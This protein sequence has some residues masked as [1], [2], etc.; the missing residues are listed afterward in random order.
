MTDPRPSPPPTSEEIEK[1]IEDARGA[2]SGKITL[3][4]GEDMDNFAKKNGIADDEGMVELRKKNSL[5]QKLAKTVAAVDGDRIGLEDPLEYK[6]VIDGPANLRDS[7]NGKN[8]RLIP[9]W[10]FGFAV[11]Q[12]ER[13]VFN[14]RVC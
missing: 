13:L 8:D 14:T 9:Q 1:A 3:P 12:E 2:C 4:G 6:K 7:P 11:R 10:F 5:R